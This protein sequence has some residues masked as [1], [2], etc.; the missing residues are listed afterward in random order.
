MIEDYDVAIGSRYLKGGKDQRGGLREI[1][2]RVGGFYIGKIMKI[3]GITDPT[4]G[5]RCF[6]RKVLESIELDTFYSQGIFVITEMLYKCYRRGFKIE[7]IPI[8]FE[9][10]KKGKSE[11]S[12]FSMISYPWKVLKLKCFKDALY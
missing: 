3:K 9:K 10:R 1:L 2:S 6:K 5:Y 12:V 4:S 11:L 7:E 8:E